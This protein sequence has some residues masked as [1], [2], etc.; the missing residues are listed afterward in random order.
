MKSI[1]IATDLSVRS[2][3]ALQRALNLAKNYKAKLTI[4]Y[5]I[6]E[7]S[8]EILHEDLSKLAKKEI[9]EAVKGKTKN[10]DY[11]VEIVTGIPH[12]KILQ[13]ALKIKADILVIGLHR[14]TN[15]VNSM[16]GSVIERVVKNSLKPVLVVRERPE[17]EYKKIL[18]AFDFN[19][20]SKN[21][22]KLAL[23]LF[24]DAN[25]TL[26]HSYHMPLLGIMGASN[27][28]LED[29]HKQDCENEMND[30]LKEVIKNISKA[31]KRSYKI[32][33]KLENGSII[34]VLNKE[35]LYS[36]AQLMVIGTNGRSGIS[37][38]LSVNVA[39]TFLID[40][41]CDVLVTF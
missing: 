2:D 7:D 24:P 11:A 40:P 25:F 3:R 39:E 10:V 18:V 19:S 14:H 6:D 22:L 23:S 13:T 33:N 20:H 9:F 35:V 34:D 36:K 31:S 28:A 8:P 30:T 32:T 15:K 26:M 4:L 41:P 21:S 27:S 17:S 16:M 37:R 29:E 1:L 5:V 12:I 38:M